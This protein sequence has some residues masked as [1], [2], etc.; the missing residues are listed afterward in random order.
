[1]LSFSFSAGMFLSFPINMSNSFFTT[2]E[3]STYRL[4]FIVFVGWSALSNTWLGDIEKD[5]AVHDERNSDTPVQEDY[6]GN[7]FLH[8]EYSLLQMH[9]HFKCNKPL[10]Q[11]G[12][13]RK[14]ALTV[15]KLQLCF[16]CSLHQMQVAYRH[17]YN[18]LEKI[19]SNLLMF[20][21]HS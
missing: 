16:S 8:Q 14:K 15:S 9:H 13:V 19:N 2:F 11:R 21:H 6:R 5:L 3:V 12:F 4:N 10:Y 1:M 7:F 18:V 17:A 20:R